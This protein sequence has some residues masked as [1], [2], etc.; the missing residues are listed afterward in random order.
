M[1]KLMA[2][3]LAITLV[4]SLAACGGNETPETTTVPGVEADA[5]TGETV[6]ETTAAEA[7]TTAV[8]STTAADETTAPEETIAEDNTTVPSGDMTRAEFADFLNAETAKIAKS[9]TYDLVRKCS[10]TRAVDIG[11]ATEP[12]NAIIKA[13]DE[14][15]SIDSVI[16]IFLGM[17][18][19][20]GKIPKDDIKGDYKIKASSVR[21]SDLG[22]FTASNGVYTFTLAK[23]SDPKKTNATP[24][25]RF[26][27]DFVTQEE[28]EASIAEF[29]SAIKVKETAVN[30]W[31]IKV[32]VTVKDGKIAE[33]KYS[34]DFDAMLAVSVAFITVPGDGA[35]V[36]NT[37]YSNIRY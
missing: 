1:K 15:S 20:Q 21:E 13:I 22:S 4:L 17:G 10:Y 11:G 36:N 12:I 16:G 2:I 19:T 37:T 7:D 9:G 24:F 6:D 3:I 28:V 23:V 34:Y 8:D 35:A 26:T 25:A 33:M 32:T 31:N 30:Y 5:T 29:T 14:N 18:T 27:N